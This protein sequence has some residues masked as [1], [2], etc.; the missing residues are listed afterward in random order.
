MQESSQTKVCTKCK[1]EKSIWDF[2]LWN[3]ASVVFEAWCRDC[4]SVA[5]TAFGRL[6]DLGASQTDYDELLAK[7]GGKCEGCGVP[8][9]RSGKALALDRCH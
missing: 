8:R 7:A 2:R 5:V 1:A 3:R 4:Q 9:S 6:R